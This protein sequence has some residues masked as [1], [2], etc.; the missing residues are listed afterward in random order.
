MQFKSF[1][2]AMVSRHWRRMLDMPR[3][4]DGSAPV[5][6]NRAVYGG[7]LLLTTTALGAIALQ[8]KQITSGKD[9][10]DM[11][12]EHAVKFWLKAFAQGGGLSIVGDML[13]NDPGIRRAT[14]MANAVAAVA[15]RPSVRPARR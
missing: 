12:G 11:H 4:R 14:A 6:G 13:L 7:A 9:P 1:P 3:F 2:I 5:L 10:I 8:A 15:A